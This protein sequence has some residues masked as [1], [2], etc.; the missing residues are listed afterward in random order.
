[1]DIDV[2]DVLRVVEEL[3]LALVEEDWAEEVVV[4][5]VEEIEDFE[6][7][8]VELSRAAVV[9]RDDVVLSVD[10]LL[11]AGVVLSFDAVVSVVLELSEE[12][13]VTELE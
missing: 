13:A 1:M 7:L 12:L 6:L 10:V 5:V 2:V 11:Y 3:V 8:L 9:L 4:S